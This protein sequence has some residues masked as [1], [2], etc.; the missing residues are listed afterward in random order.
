MMNYD[1]LKKR[2]RKENRFQTPIK[3]SRSNLNLSNILINYM[4]NNANELKRRIKDKKRNI[5]VNEDT[6]E[7]E[8]KK[9]KEEE[10]EL[11][12]LFLRLI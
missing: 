3:K 6:D 4:V 7:E 2:K 11:M 10:E 9:K 1:K 8:E 5:I 12:I